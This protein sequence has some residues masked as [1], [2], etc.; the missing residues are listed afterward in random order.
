[1]KLGKSTKVQREITKQ[2]RNK[3]NN[4]KRIT[5]ALIGGV[6][7][8]ILLVI[9]QKSII[10]QEAKQTVYQ[11][12]KDIASGTKLTEKNISEYL[13]FKDVQASLI[14]EGYIT[15]KQDILNKFT[16]RDYKA[17]DIITVDGVN[18]T[19]N[20]YTSSIKNPV[21]ISF[22]VSAINQSVNGVIRE[23]DWINIYGMQGADN[24]DGYVLSKAYKFQHVYVTK[25]FDNSGELIG[26]EKKSDAKAATT[27]FSVLIDEKDAGQFAE[28]IANCNIRVAKLMYNTDTDY[29]AYVTVTNSD[30]T[31]TDGN[32]KTISNS[33]N[34]QNNDIT[35]NTDAVNDENAWWNKTVD[36]KNAGTQEGTKLEEATEGI[37]EKNTKKETPK[38]EKTETPVEK[39]ETPVENTEETTTNEG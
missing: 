1:M 20:K 22:A 8:F 11:V 13:R 6:I 25:A 3:Q 33:N 26:S 15:N 19:E 2:E 5:A 34:T 31:V 28:M 4:I 30:G 7:I 37:N 23:G 10:N 29:Q 14:P 24:S 35:Q 16:N 36:W 9:I 12:S 21:E 18:D 39:T 32:G 17:N 38:E 27:S